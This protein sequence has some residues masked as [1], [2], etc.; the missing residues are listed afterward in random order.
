[1][2]SFHLPQPK[3]AW[4]DRFGMVLSYGCAVHCAAMPFLAS[5]IAVGGF[6]W[7]L[8]E[9]TEWAI[10]IASLSIGLTRLFYSY[11][12]E[13]RRPEPVV[14]FLLGAAAILLAK[15]SLE[16]LHEA[17]EPLAMVA[18]GILI[19]TAH[20]RNQA[21]CKCCV[22]AAGALTGTDGSVSVES[23]SAGANRQ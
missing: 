12:V 19:G 6:S 3:S 2:E 17:A 7:L 1:M 16:G 23:I 14:L 8:E 20:Y 22:P 4:W 18:G 15:N 10:I 9:S 21:H 13:H 11:F 5:F